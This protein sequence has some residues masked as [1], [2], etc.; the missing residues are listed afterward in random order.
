MNAT[1]L[2]YLSSKKQILERLY[3]D[4]NISFDEL[5]TL[6]N[7]T[8]VIHVPYPYQPPYLYNPD[9]N[10]WPLGQ[11]ICKSGMVMD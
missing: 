4:G 8:Q 9:L 6:A 7:E 10:Q 5:W 3:K 1:T 11:T 2:N